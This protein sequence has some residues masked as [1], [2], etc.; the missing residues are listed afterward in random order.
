MSSL[1]VHSRQPE[2]L[3]DLAG[4]AGS[5][6]TEISRLEYQMDRIIDFLA[7]GEE[8]KKSL[9][10]F[11][12]ET[13]DGTEQTNWVPVHL[14]EEAELVLAFQKAVREQAIRC[15]TL[16]DQYK[17]IRWQFYARLDL[18]LRGWPV[19]RKGYH[20]KEDNHIA[21]FDH[22]YPVW[23]REAIELV[24]ENREFEFIEEEYGRFVI[25]P[26]CQKKGAC[27]TQKSDLH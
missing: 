24:E 8:T 3:L 17:H 19:C 26:I 21:T 11:A 18:V 4:L 2:H 23:K 22:W 7:L 25:R 20:S 6:W 14:E 1:D 10:A 13:I 16:S 12:K 9:V 27:D 5:S 15:K